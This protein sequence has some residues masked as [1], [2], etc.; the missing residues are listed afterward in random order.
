MVGGDFLGEEQWRWLEM[1]LL[2]DDSGISYY[3][4]SM[5]NFLLMV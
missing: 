5:N 3:F 1:Q 2:S 4:I